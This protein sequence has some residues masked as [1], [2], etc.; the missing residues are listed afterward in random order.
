MHKIKNNEIGEAC[1][2]YGEETRRVQ[3]LVGETRG[4][5]IT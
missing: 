5:D 4:K 1:S 3:S 2:M